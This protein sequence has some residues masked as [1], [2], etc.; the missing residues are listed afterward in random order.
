ML[1][2]LALFVAEDLVMKA[3]ILGVALIK[4]SV[5]LLIK[6]AR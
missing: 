4:T 6:T 1:G 2:Y 5:L 3:L